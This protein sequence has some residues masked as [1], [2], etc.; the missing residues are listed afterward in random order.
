MRKP[1]P[2]RI[3]VAIDGHTIPVSVR[4]ISKKNPV[5]T[6]AYTPP[7]QPRVRISTGQK[8]LADALAFAR[9]FDYNAAHTEAQD[10]AP[11]E[12][13]NES[14]P[15]LSKIFAWYTDTYLPNRNT[16][17]GSIVDI[18]GSLDQFQDWAR[19]NRITRVQ[20]VRPARIEEFIKFLRTEI[21]NS[22]RTIEKKLS[23]LRSCFN[24]ATAKELID[25]P[26][27]DRWEMPRYPKPEIDF[28]NPDQLRTLLAAIL[29]HCGR[30]APAIQ[31]IAATGNRPEGA[32]TV[33]WKHIDLD[34]AIIHRPEVKVKHLAT[35]P[36]SPLAITAITAAPGDKSKPTALVFPAPRSGQPYGKNT[37]RNIFQT[38]ITAAGLD[39]D[40]AWVNLKTLR[41][42]FGH[43][44]ANYPVHNGAPMPLPMLQQCMGHTDIQTTMKYV[45]PGDAQPY[46][47]GFANLITPETPKKTRK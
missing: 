42:T 34:R 28:L 6:L 5:Y 25:A 3:H 9:A 23:A 36:I 1:S 30:H 22:P 20:Q 41:H 18:E 21:K 47:T 15:R 14:D 19:R 37:L 26:P 11:I 29:P 10:A 17:P 32:R 35:Y 12:I 16:A 13:S 39:H 7:G 45:K 33:Q 40:F 38:A 2:N 46:L 4:H 44:N 27:V 43:I 31:F 8:D 24:A